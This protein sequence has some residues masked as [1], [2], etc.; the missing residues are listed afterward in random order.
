MT[1]LVDRDIIESQLKYN[2]A[3][4]FQ[5]LASTDPRTVMIL[6]SLN[7]AFRWKHSGETDFLEAYIK[8]VESL[9]KSYNCG[10]VIIACDKGSSSYRKRIYD[11]YKQNRKDKQA[12][13]TPEEQAAFERFFEEFMR[14]IDNFA[15]TTNYP[16]FRFDKVEADDVAAYIVKH[17]RDFNIDNVVLVSSDRD[18]DLLVAPDVMRFSYVTRKEV[19]WDNYHEHYEWT[20][21]QYISIKCLQGDAGDNVPGVPGIGPKKA[22][23]LIQQYE[24]TYDIIASLPINSKYK[25][26]QNLNDFGGDRLILN[27][28]LMDLLEFCEE[29]I[30]VENIDTINNT[31][32]EYLNES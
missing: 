25:Y 17:R 18:W 12:L 5:K 7:L 4:T 1:L 15:E 29:A 14:V 13:S 16:V 22:M 23:A 20:P 26:I 19:T 10:K 8:T 21:E 31:L 30:G 28:Q 24:T 6:D 3:K 9:R 27:Y 32:E 2:M 11:D